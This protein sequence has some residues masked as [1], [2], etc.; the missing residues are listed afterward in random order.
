M[1]LQFGIYTFI[2]GGSREVGPYEKQVH[3][4]TQEKVGFSQRGKIN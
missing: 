1:L 4:D 2:V 3:Q